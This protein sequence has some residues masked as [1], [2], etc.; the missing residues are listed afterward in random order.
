MRNIAMKYCLWSIAS[1]MASDEPLD[2]IELEANLGDAVKPP[3]VPA[4]KKPGEIQDIEI[5][6]SGAGNRYY[7]IK[8][9]IDPNDL[10]EEMR[11]IYEDGAVLFW[12]RQIVPRGA[13]DR[14]ALFN[15]K[16]FYTNIGLDNNITSVDPNDWMGCK[17]LLT[18]KHGTYNGEVRAEIAAIAPLDKAPA[19]TTRQSAGEKQTIA[20]KDVGKI[21]AAARRGRG[22]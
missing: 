9:V 1:M 6:T 4:G 5:K 3:E 22:K 21:P 19:R 2:I 20:A 15:L 7:A 18:I 17:A 8:F 12:N 10:P 14:R 11:E 16:Q 13:S